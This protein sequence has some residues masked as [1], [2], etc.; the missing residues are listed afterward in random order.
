MLFQHIGFQQ[1]SFGTNPD[2]RC[3]YL[4]EAHREALASPRIAV[5]TP[6]ACVAGVIR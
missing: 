4:S 2:P 5:A 6:L 1:D 3:L